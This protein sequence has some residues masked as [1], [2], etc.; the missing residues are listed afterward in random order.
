[1]P[2][3][4]ALHTGHTESA[5]T[6]EFMR[7]TIARTALALA[8]ASLLA[9]AAAC[10]HEPGDE[11]PP[12]GPPPAVVAL[13]SPIPPPPG[14]TP[15][16]T[17]T[18]AAPARPPAAG[19]QLV[20]DPNHP[21]ER[22]YQANCAA[23]HDNPEAT[24][25]PAKAAL[26]TMSYQF[27]NFT[28][29]RGKMQA[30][31]ASLTDEQ[32]GTLIGY[33]VGRAGVP[34]DAWAQSAMCPA[35]RRAVN[36]TGQVVA[37][38]FGFDRNNTRSLSARQ[39]GLTRAQLSNMELAWT[40]AYPNVAEMRAQGAI[41]GTTMFL[42]VAATGQMYAIDISQPRP[43]FKWIYTAPGGAPLRTSAAYGTLADGTPLLVFS[44]LDSTVHAVDPRTGRAL[45]T[46]GVGSYSYSMTTGTPTILKDRIIVPVAQF[47]ISV[48]ANNDIPCCNNHGYVLSLDPKTG[49]QQWRYDTMP[50]ATPLRDRGDGKPYY[51]PSGAPVWNSPVVD[52]RR[53]LIY[54]GTGEANS[55]P[56]H[57]NTNA[58]IAI[59]LADGRQ[60][61]A[62]QATERDVFLSGCGLTPAANRYNCARDTVYRDVDFGAS[63]VLGR[64]ANGRDVLFAG[65]KSG[66]AW[67]LNPDTGEVIWRREIGTGGA[68]GGIHWGIAF[69]NDTLYVPISNI[70]RQ[71]PGGP[72]IDPAL[73]AGMYALNAATGEIK[74]MY[75]PEPPPAVVPPAPA[76]G[77]APAPARPNQGARNAA[78]S[79][80]PLV[81][82]GA[83]V[84][85]ALDGTLY[86]IDASNGRLLWS[87][88]TNQTYADTITGI[89]G[90]GG[91]I[92]AVSIWAGGGYL[93]ANSG[94]GQ[95][96]EIPGNVTLAFRPRR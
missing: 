25:S 2:D 59:G 93:F 20:T 55:A 85:G 60:R 48:A 28:L 82:D 41:I 27:I 63:M 89:A 92:D 7:I 68:L 42:P 61:W 16:S 49:A 30:Q 69:A 80:V 37:Q 44:G 53:G 83:V 1:L 32:R 26:R 12:P 73:K 45:W 86:V 56:A 66:T 35:D 11:A 87:Y 40:I 71:L 43:C 22:L 24:R 77:A 95:F 23:C 9:I 34:N 81:V 65:Q 54:F 84:A 10:Q 52:E 88:Q 31:G 70:G 76:P 3:D 78:F 6:E 13:Q 5:G 18:A 90:K 4:Q 72:P 47:E 29:T 58:I 79:A 15:T 50:D 21:G 8:S 19:P 91:S 39:A 96:G 51:G 64:L 46:K 57:V 17:P 33:L 62:R 67:A 74:W 36:L 14:P 75:S 94:Y 38:G